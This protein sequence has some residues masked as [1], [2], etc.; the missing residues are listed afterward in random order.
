MW[1][2]ISYMC[3]ACKARAGVGCLNLKSRNPLV[4]FHKERIAMAH[5]NTGRKVQGVTRVVRFVALDGTEHETTGAARKHN[6]ETEFARWLDE[7]LD[8][9]MGHGE[10]FVSASQI[11]AHIRE[12][13]HVSRKK[14]LEVAS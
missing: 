13:W 11:A 7:Y 14:S 1:A 9:N 6:T 2:T 4:G 5:G 12:Y 3:P 10:L 8:A